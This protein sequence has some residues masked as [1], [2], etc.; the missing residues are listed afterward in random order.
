MQKTKRGTIIIS[1]KEADKLSPEFKKKL[2]NAFADALFGQMGYERVAT[3]EK[4][5]KVET[6]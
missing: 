1:T 5:T 6:A 4:K 2:G 3:R